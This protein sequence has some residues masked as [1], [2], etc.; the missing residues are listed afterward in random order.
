V[1]FRVHPKVRDDEC[2]RESMRLNRA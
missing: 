1:A 2:Q